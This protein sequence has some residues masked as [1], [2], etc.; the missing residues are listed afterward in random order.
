MWPLLVLVAAMPARRLY[1]D[2]PTRTLY[3]NATAHT[4]DAARPTATAWCVGGAPRAARFLAVGNITAAA[5]ECGPMAGAVD[6]LGAVVVP[7]MIDSHL[8]LLYGGL[9]LSRPVLDSCSSAA[10]VVR[11]LQE[12]VSSHT[13]PPRGWLQGFGWDQE[14]FPSRAFPTRADLD[15]AFPTTPV[16]LTRIDGHA[17]WANSEALRRTPPLPATD[18]AGGR[19]VRDATGAPTGVFTD[20]AMSLVDAHIPPPSES[21]QRD[22]LALALAL[23]AQ[24][25]LTSIHDPGIDQSEVELLMALADEG[26]LTLRSYAMLLGN[27]AG[28]GKPASPA[29][30]AMVYPA[31]RGR[32]TVRAV[33]F[34][35]DGALGSRGAAM[36]ADYADA[37]GQ[38]G[39]LRMSEAEYRANTSAWLARGWQLATHAI[40]DRANRIVLGV[41]SD[42]CAVGGSAAAAPDLR[43]R[44]EHFQIVNTTDLPRV[45]QRGEAAGGGHACILASMQPTHATSDMA[46]AE[47]RLGPERL[48][49]AY[50]WQA[51]LD[52]GAAALPFGSDWP[53]VGVVPPLLGIH[54][55]VT[56]QDLHGS[57]PGG[58][59]PHQRVS[60]EQA[61]RGYT[62]DAAFAAFE[63]EELGQIRVGYHADFV[64]LD[65]DILDEATVPDDEIW[66]AAILATWSGGERVWAHPCWLRATAAPREPARVWTAGDDCAAR[67]FPARAEALRGC[68]E[69]ERARG[70][71]PSESALARMRRL[72]AAAGDGCPF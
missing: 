59:L 56:R 15:A 70:G 49:G 22:A 27:A 37:P 2:A 64:A 28:L 47:A 71:A 13:L 69:T 26:H 8:H 72:S 35:M 39:Q 51:V 60:R 12:Y 68:V 34:F 36:L 42:A 16:W 54:A 61:L 40:G 44:I 58:W 7:G 52:V 43:L 55:A 21:Q 5:A 63:E 53:T 31:Y 29:T 33:K 50:A 19:I 45:H 25:G 46:Y 48:K 62:S 41:Y 11:V 1:S 9:K 24:S 67:S 20:A 66:Q 57:P 17:A 30:A 23:A 18:P 65:R 32:L 38:A 10:D 6:L 3:F 14:R 4:M